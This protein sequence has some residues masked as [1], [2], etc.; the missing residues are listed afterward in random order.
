M[1]VEVKNIRGWIYPG[2]A[3]LHQLLDK[4]ARLQVA[5]PER[6]ILPVLVCRKAHYLTTVMARQLGFYVIS[7]QRQYVPPRLT[8]TEEDARY[9]SE[10][11]KELGYDLDPYSGPVDAMVRHFTQTLP[12]VAER[13][14]TL[15]A[16]T[17]PTLG[18]YFYIL[19]QDHLPAPER[20]LLTAALAERAAA[21][22]GQE[23]KWKR[24]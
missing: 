16:R 14:A 5:H 2:A 15:W 22:Y 21:T 19:R 17:G 20:V 10:I 24:V 3:E 6:H 11:Q 13:S 7:M 4:A 8:E 1:L 18:Q 9:L 23:Q 12:S